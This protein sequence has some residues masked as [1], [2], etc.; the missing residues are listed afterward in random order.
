MNTPER[1][2]NAKY[3]DVPEQIRKIYEAG[4]SPELS[5]G[6]TKRGMY[7]YG[8]VGCGKT[9]YCYGLKANYDRPIQDTPIGYRPGRYAPLWNMT[10]LLRDMRLDI[11]RHE[12]NHIEEEVMENEGLIFIDDIGAEKISDWVAETFYLI[13]NKRYNEMRPTVFTS[14]LKPDDLKERIGDRTVSRI[15][16]MCDVVELVGSDRRL[17]NAKKTQIKI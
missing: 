16:E 1:F 5:M 14:N 9:H 15:V 2:K 13:V 10:E 11:D 7:I 17:Q 12:K 4:M 8:S 3:E 6:E